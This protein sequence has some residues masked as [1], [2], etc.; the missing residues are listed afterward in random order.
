MANNISKVILIL[1][2]IFSSYVYADNKETLIGVY[3]YIFEPDI[4]NYVKLETSEWEGYVQPD[5]KNEDYSHLFIKE[6]N[7]SLKYT[8]DIENSAGESPSIIKIENLYKC[9][10]KYLVVTTREF[11]NSY[12]EKP[13]FEYQRFIISITDNMFIKSVYDEQSTKSGGVL[14]ADISDPIN[15]ALECKNK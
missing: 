5:N 2:F 1:S 7:G 12:G 15:S 3:S 4:G 11:F 13:V 9:N 10:K 6:K 14:M 8:I